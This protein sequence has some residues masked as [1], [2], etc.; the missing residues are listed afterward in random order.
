MNLNEHFTT[1]EIQKPSNLV[2]QQIQG[3]I[4]NG[5]LKP[6]DKLPPERQMAERLGISRNYVREAI[7][8]LEW[9]GIIETKPQSGS[10]VS[11]LGIRSLTGFITTALQGGQDFQDLID[12][13]KL[14][15]VQSIIQAVERADSD[16]IEL[17]LVR[18]KAFV[19][20]TKSGDGAV[21]ED[22]A[23]HLTIADVSKNR[24]IRTFLGIITPD[25]LES[26]RT[27]ASWTKGRIQ[28]T[29]EEHER[30]VNAIITKDRAAAKQAM[31]EHMERTRKNFKKKGYY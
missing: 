3:L 4:R 22:L 7:K 13:R 31:E 14:L 6:G 2:I 24:V 26:S 10:T 19:E 9:Y 15:E 21:E 11:A 18:H 12:V 27:V 30:I 8:Q 17:L 5:V 23:F 29:I 28:K 25:L 20:K 16:E 1:I